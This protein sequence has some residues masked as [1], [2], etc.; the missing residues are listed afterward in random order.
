MNMQVKH[1]I[2]YGNRLMSGNNTFA[3]ILHYDN[4]KRITVRLKTNVNFWDKKCIFQYVTMFI[5]FLA[6]VFSFISLMQ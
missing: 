5:S 6:V 3:Y 2:R 4:G 1:K